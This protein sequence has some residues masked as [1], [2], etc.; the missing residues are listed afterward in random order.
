MVIE[1]L[2]G[3]LPGLL[4]SFEGMHAYFFPQLRQRIV[5]LLAVQTNLPA[6]TNGASHPSWGVQA[7]P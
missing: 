6:G 3:V 2:A 1:V 7:V 5:S 4:K